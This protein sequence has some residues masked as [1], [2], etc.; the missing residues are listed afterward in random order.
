MPLDA[1]PAENSPEIIASYRDALQEVITRSPFAT[2]GV[3]PHTVQ[4][5]RA[6]NPYPLIQEGGV[7]WVIGKFYD[8]P[9]GDLADTRTD[10]AM[11]ASLSAYGIP[12]HR[13]I[14]KS[15]P[16]LGMN[17]VDAGFKSLVY[18]TSNSGGFG[19]II[20][21]NA[22][23][24]ANIKPK[25][26]SE[27][28]GGQPYV[29]VTLANGAIVHGY[30][31]AVGLS[32][33][34]EQIEKHGAKA[35]EIDVSANDSKF[36]SLDF[37]PYF[38]AH[39]TAVLEAQTYGKSKAELIG[40][41]EKG[42]DTLL[43]DPAIKHFLKTPITPDRLPDV[44]KNIYVET[45]NFGNG[46]VSIS[47]DEIL[48]LGVNPSKEPLVFAAQGKDDQ[49]RSKASLTDH[50]GEQVV[51]NGD[52]F[53][54]PISVL[55]ISRSSKPVDTA[56]RNW[57]ETGNDNRYATT[58]LRKSKLEDPSAVSELLIKEGSVFAAVR[59]QTLENL[60]NIAWQHGRGHNFLGDA[61]LIGKLSDEG[62]VNGF[63][64][65]KLEDR[66]QLTLENK[67]GGFSKEELKTFF[68]VS[69]ASPYSGARR[70]YRAGAQ[71][72]NRVRQAAH[73][74]FN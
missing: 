19:T 50:N 74:A 55:N 37:E 3:Y 41:A 20:P 34:K 44:P 48:A 45:D 35:W 10:G 2:E 64:A 68:P 57:S 43:E 47:Y 1:S 6:Q 52:S 17:S 18:A 23:G 59:P 72:A 22:A 66:I 46:V 36:R 49:W 58:F 63:D 28:N 26:G 54:V 14:L 42:I 53:N 73:Y 38:N 15:F 24:R 62:L 12:S 13:Y 32:F 5:F 31:D 40:I 27:K 29:L 4:K 16:T 9:N 8:Y 60:R 39:L 70:I 61:E 56:A 69:Y 11:I 30:L 25:D 51:S 71:A 21:I 7:N 65:R 67:D 33:Y